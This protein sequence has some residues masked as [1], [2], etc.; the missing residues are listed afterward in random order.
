MKFK[1]LA[2]VIVCCIATTGCTQNFVF[3]IGPEKEN[4][5]T[6][7]V[8]N[9]TLSNSKGSYNKGINLQLK[10]KKQSYLQR[11]QDIRDEY[12]RIS[13]EYDQGKHCTATLR[14]ISAKSY[15]ES[16]KILNEI[17]Q[18]LRK[19]MP[20]DIMEK[21][22]KDQLEWIAKK[23][24][25]EKHCREISTGLI[26][27]QQMYYITEERCKILLDYLSNE[28][29]VVHKKNTKNN[30]NLNIENNKDV[31][32][33]KIEDN[34]KENNMTIDEVISKLHDLLD[35]DDVKTDYVFSPDDNYVKG[36]S[37]NPI[38]VEDYYIFAV[39]DYPEGTDG[40]SPDNNIIVNRE[41]LEVYTYGADGS[42]E[43]LGNIN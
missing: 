16:D 33:E 8:K 4:V 40:V 19:Y 2:M 13:S 1:L 29:C 37:L 27:D 18:D 38:N 39:V 36:N 30:D 26:T 14:N 6:S 5:K 10:D 31:Y 25:E 12:E 3:K 43:K 34:T 42:M 23:E 15:K 17:Y 24:K 21:I 11:L 35:S 32:N 9:S 22:K 41:T 28:D 20:S 7:N